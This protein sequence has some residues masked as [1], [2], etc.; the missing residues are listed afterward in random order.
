MNF[1][2]TFFDGFRVERS[3]RFVWIIVDVRQA[4]RT[5][6]KIL[7]TIPEAWNLQCI[8]VADEH[9]CYVWNY[10]QWKHVVHR[11]EEASAAVRDDSFIS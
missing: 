2:L 6:Q 11:I 8:Q 10:I 3:E 7:A 5:L 4:T 9:T 1:C